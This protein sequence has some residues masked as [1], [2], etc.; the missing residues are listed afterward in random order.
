MSVTFKQALGFAF[1]LVLALVALA[2]AAALVI[3]VGILTPW[4]VALPVGVVLVMVGFATMIYLMGKA[5]DS[6]SDY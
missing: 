1:W 5:M 4:W 3:T 2:A 6:G